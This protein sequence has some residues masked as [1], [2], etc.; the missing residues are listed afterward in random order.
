MF[1]RSARLALR[2]PRLRCLFTYL[3]E[4]S[5]ISEFEADNV[6]TRRA[7]WSILVGW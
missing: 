4:M 3:C 7:L 1:D 5:P 2:K 6:G